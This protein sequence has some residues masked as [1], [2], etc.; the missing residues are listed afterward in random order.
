MLTAA[1]TANSLIV[2]WATVTACYNDFTAIQG[3]IEGF[4]LVDQFGCNQSFMR[5]SAAAPKFSCIEMRGK[6]G[7]II[8][9]IMID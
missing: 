6:L 2:F 7:T 1:R 5:F 9:I 4:Q 3:S 8:I